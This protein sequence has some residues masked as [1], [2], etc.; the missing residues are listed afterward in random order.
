MAKGVD[1][2]ADRHVDSESVAKVLFTIQALSDER[3]AVWKITVRLQPPTV[4]ERPASVADQLP[5]PREERRI[6]FFYPAVH[7]GLAPRKDHAGMVGEQLCR[8]PARADSL[9]AALGPAPKKDGVQVG[10][11]NHV[12]SWRHYRS[13]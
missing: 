6:Q 2:V 7:Y 3:F 5:D 9:G 4:D 10:V 12:Q 13:L 1:V 11:P 8:S